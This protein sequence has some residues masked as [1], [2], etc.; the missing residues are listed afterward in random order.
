MDR[1]SLAARI[2]EI[3]KSRPKGDSRQVRPVGQAS[4]PPPGSGG[5]AEAEA[6]AGVLARGPRLDPTD[7]SA[8]FA[9]RCAAAE[10]SSRVLE[11]LGATLLEDASG[12][13]VVVDRHYPLTHRHG[14]HDVERYRAAVRASRRVAAVLPREDEPVASVRAVGGDRRTAVR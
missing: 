9:R 13:C 11:V 1:A 8:A 3:L 10:A 2:Q 12:P 7:E 5:P 6:K 4:P 14:H